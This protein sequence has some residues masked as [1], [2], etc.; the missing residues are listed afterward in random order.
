MN[1]VGLNSKLS[2]FYY[3]VVEV[4]EGDEVGRKRNDVVVFFM[5]ALADLENVFDVV[6]SVTTYRVSD[7][8][9]FVFH[10]LLDHFMGQCVIILA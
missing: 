5:E 3:G 8:Y 10:I 7:I 6:G 9:Y 2:F 1:F 4:L